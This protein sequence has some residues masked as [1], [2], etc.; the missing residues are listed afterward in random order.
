MRDAEQGRAQ[1][2]PLQPDIPSP[3]RGRIQ[4]LDLLRGLAIAL[5]LIR[6]S[7]L[8]HFGGGGIVGVV[9]FFALS[10]Y[11][12]TGLLV[13]DLTSYGRIRYGR[14]YLHRATR[15]LPALFALLAV[16]SIITFIWNPLRVDRGHSV[17]V[18]LTGLTY[19]ANIP[20]LPQGGALGHL[21]TLATEEQFYLV[22]PILLALGLRF[23]RMKLMAVIAVVG[24][25]AGL[26]LELSWK[27]GHIVEIY[28]M[29]FSWAL[30]I[31]I[32]A[33]ARLGRDR[34]RQVLPG[35]GAPRAALSSLALVTLLGLCFLPDSKGEPIMYLLGGPLIA[36]CTVVL[37]F[38]LE[39]WVILPYRWMRPALALG[40]ISYAAYLWNY[41]VAVWLAGPDRVMTTP[42]RVATIFLTIA[43]AT[44]SWFVVER[45]AQRWRQR[46]DARRAE[47]N[48]ATA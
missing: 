16:F 13:K 14:F 20:N 45:P 35:A 36:L 17:G 8:I 48:L 44:V 3:A 47:R 38:H 4:G 2:T 28:T 22:W 31:V 42:Q 25:L 27:A 11:L 29:P 5:V 21:W 39:T 41:P 32:G 15:L 34:I 7:Q 46:F 30:A 19:T 37:I 40:T 9:I 43:I 10:G 23:R 18:V 12:I 26:L 1:P 6:H 24:A 33:L